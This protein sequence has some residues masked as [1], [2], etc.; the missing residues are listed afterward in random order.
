MFSGGDAF[1]SGSL[2]DPQGSSAIAAAVLWVQGTLLGSIAVAVAVVAVASVGLMML[3]GRIDLRR[4]MTVIAGCFVLFGA[5]TIAGGIQSMLNG[6]DEDID[7]S[8]EAP[9]PV[10]P[11]PALPPAPANA[12]PYA[13]ASVPA[14]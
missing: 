6:R 12:D 11:P 1:M 8:A 3:G 5:P 2:A 9:P 4:G 13:G 10:P 7:A 14:R